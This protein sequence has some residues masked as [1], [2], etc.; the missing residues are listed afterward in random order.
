MKPRTGAFLGKSLEH[1]G[2]MLGVGLQEAAGRTAY[3]A[4]DDAAQAVIF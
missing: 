4:G 1:A 2:T 3:L